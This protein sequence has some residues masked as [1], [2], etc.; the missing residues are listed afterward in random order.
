MAI[1]IDKHEA[2]D[3]IGALLGADGY[4]YCDL[5]D[6]GIIRVENG[7]LSYELGEMGIFSPPS[8]VTDFAVEHNYWGTLIRVDCESGLS[9]NL[10]VKDD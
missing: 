5:A 7:K 2:K 3:L 4:D 9:L 8:I 1:M 10:S 6:L